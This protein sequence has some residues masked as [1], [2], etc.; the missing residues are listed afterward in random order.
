LATKGLTALEKQTTNVDVAAKE[1]DT[2]STANETEK[3]GTHQELSS[4]ATAGSAMRGTEKEVVRQGVSTQKIAERAK[5][6][7]R[8]APWVEYPELAKQTVAHSVDHRKK[9][10][11]PKYKKLANPGAAAEDS[12]EGEP[13][14]QD[15]ASAD[16]NP[17]P[18]SSDEHGGSSG[19]RWKRTFIPLLILI[20]ILALIL[21][22]IL[23]CCLFLIEADKSQYVNKSNKYNTFMIFK[24][25][26]IERK[27][28]T[29]FYAVTHK[30]TP[31]CRGNQLKQSQVG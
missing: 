2:L 27:L 23:I 21:I 9:N 30:G 10:F 1:T 18:A 5:Y 17:P 16:K 3:P 25:K 26:K 24:M 19:T 11:G 31:I 6:K 7:E 22:F 28:E 8:R 14:M 13:A 20:I 15:S 4:Q 29:N 12:G